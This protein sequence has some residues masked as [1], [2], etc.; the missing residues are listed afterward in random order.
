M[1]RLFPSSMPLLSILLWSGSASAATM[2]PGRRTRDSIIRDTKQFVLNLV[3]EEMAQAM[4]IT[5]IDFERGVSEISE[6]GL[7]TR[8]SVYIKPPRIAASPVAM[9]CELMQI[10]A[11]G[12]DTG[13]VLGRVLAMHV[14]KDFVIDPAKYIDSPGLKLIGRIHSGWY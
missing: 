8:P 10:V 13:L 7:K 4:N 2:P 14:R 6:A 12:T 1:R 9:E 3:S 5:A 11:L